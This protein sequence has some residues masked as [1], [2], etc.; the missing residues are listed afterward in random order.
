MSTTPDGGP[1]FPAPNYAVHSDTSKETI[2]KLADTQ[3]MTLRDWFAG[4]AIEVV[5]NLSQRGDGSWDANDVAAGCYSIADA[6]LAARK[7]AQ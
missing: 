3:G 4:Q 2:L 6:M 7:A 1:A 5:T